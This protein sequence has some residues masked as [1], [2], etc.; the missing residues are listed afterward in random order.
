VTAPPVTAAALRVESQ[1]F[2]TTPIDV[3]GVAGRDAPVPRRET[4]QNRPTDAA[5]HIPDVWAA[6]AAAIGVRRM[7]WQ[8]VLAKAVGAVAMATWHQYLFCADPLGG[9]IKPRAGVGAGGAAPG[10]NAW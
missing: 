1:R 7:D 9:Q 2:T 6:I 3:D 8:V 4:P 10:L 5:T